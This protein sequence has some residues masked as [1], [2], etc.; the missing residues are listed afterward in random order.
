MASTSDASVQCHQ[1]EANTRFIA[2]EDGSTV[3]DPQNWSSLKKLCHIGPVASLVMAVVL[4]SSIISPAAD[5]IAEEFEV[6]REAAI[7]P[8][9]RE[10]LEPCS[11]LPILTRQALFTF[12]FG[13]GPAFAAPLSETFGRSAVYKITAAIYFLFVLGSALTPTL[14]G[15]LICRLL[16]GMAGGPCVPITG[17][18]T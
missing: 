15:L 16:A 10:S 1:E 17:G 11:I 9:V 13:F 14:V 2:L 6:S 5:Q 7:L 18:T 4:G 12:G 3:V 8:F